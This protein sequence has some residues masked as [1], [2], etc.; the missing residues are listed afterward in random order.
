MSHRI[1]LKI[2]AASGAIVLGSGVAAA[3]L[4]TP[5]QAADGLAKAAEKAGFE[6]PVATG[7]Q[8]TV[9]DQSTDVTEEESTEAEVEVEDE[10]TGAVD[11]HGAEVSE[12]ARNTELIGREKGQ[13]I[14]ALASEGRSGGPDDTE[15][16]ADVEATDDGGTDTSTEAIE[17]SDTTESDHPAPQA[18]AGSAN[19][20][21]HRP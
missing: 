14:A 18:A 5:D 17:D 4:T 13:A 1:S 7:A 19:A 8:S 6:V 12:L 21:G 20:E 11:N 2:V 10:G 16:S 3:A 9:D 15:D